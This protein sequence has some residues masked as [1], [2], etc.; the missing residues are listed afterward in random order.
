MLVVFATPPF[1]FAT[2]N[3]VMAASLA[4]GSVPVPLHPPVAAVTSAGEYVVGGCR[5]YGMPTTDTGEFEE[6]SVPFPSWPLSFIPQ[7]FAPP[8]GVRAQVWSKP[9]DTVDAVRPSTVTGVVEGPAAPFPSW[10]SLSLPQQ[11]TDPFVRVTHVWNSP[12]VIEVASV[13]PEGE[14]GTFELS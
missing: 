7:H 8:V 1:W 4:L 2:A 6:T 5:T 13:I 3:V 11:R 14:T 10:P 9:A 12:V